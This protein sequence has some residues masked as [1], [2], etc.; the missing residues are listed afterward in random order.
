MK[1]QINKASQVCG[2][3]VNRSRLPGEADSPDV[4]GRMQKRKIFKKEW[5]EKFNKTKWKMFALW[6]II[7][8]NI[9]VWRSRSLVM[10]IVLK[11]MP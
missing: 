10:G 9:V 5:Q 11:Y 1:F 6:I 8:N 3:F 2:D 7:E 4:R